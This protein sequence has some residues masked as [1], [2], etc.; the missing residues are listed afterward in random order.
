MVMSISPPLAKVLS[1]TSLAPCRRPPI[2]NCTNKN[3]QKSTI[4]I[5][6]R[7]MT[8]YISTVLTYRFESVR[9]CI[10]NAACVV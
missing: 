1:H 8:A 9:P 2:F 7:Y 10:C 6:L 5:K 4:Y 3:I